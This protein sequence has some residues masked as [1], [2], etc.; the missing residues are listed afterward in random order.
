[1]YNEECTISRHS[2]VEER[3]LHKSFFDGHALALPNS[4]VGSLPR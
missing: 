4:S 2:G 3:F 1:M